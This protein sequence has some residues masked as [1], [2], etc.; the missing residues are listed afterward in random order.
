M[1]EL[2]VGDII[3]CHKSVIMSDTH[4]KVTSIGKKYRIE[5]IWHDNDKITIKNDLNRLHHFS[6]IEG[7]QSYYK[8]W[9]NNIK[10]LRYKKLKKLNLL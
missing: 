1:E 3:V 9:F 7:E 6:L 5:R 4:D 2:K 8:I 10:F